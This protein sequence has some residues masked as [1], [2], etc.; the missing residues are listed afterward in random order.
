MKQAILRKKSESRPMHAP[1]PPTNSLVSL[2]LP[3]TKHS[4]VFHH[5]ELYQLFVSLHQHTADQLSLGCGVY[6]GKHQE[7]EP[8][9]NC[10]NRETC[11]HCYNHNYG[12][13]YHDLLVSTTIE[14][15]VASTM[16]HKVRLA[17]RELIFLPG[18]LLQW[19]IVILK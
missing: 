19:D 15:T 8:R 9:R 1:F 18:Y 13:S 17:S 12:N 16:W 6:H 14:S 5:C 11:N 4:P 7:E 3:P 10:N 2:S